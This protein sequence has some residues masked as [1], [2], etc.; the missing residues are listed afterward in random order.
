M[1]SSVQRRIA[2]IGGGITG[3]AAAHRLHELLPTA[4]ISL[5]EGSDR[6]G[7]VLHS[8]ERDGY[9]IERSADMFNTREPWAL[10]LAQR[11]GLTN[12]LINTDPRFRRAF[13][14]HRGK[15]CPVPEGF[16]LMSPAKVWPILKTPLLSP[17]GKLRLASE[18]FI[19]GKRDDQDESLTSFALR[20]FGREAFDR[21][22]QP[23]IGGIYT[24]DPDRLSMQATLK[25]FVEHERKYG[26]LIRAMR[27]MQ[28]TQP[29][30][31]K[32]AAAS[33]A[34]YG[35]FL[36]PRLG[37]SQL[38]DAIANHLPAGSIRLNARIERL[39]RTPHD[40]GVNWCLFVQGS[41]AP[42][43]FDD[44]IVASPA[45][46]CPPLL[47]RI[48]PQL[49]GLVKLIPH[50]G[51]S[52]AVMG[53]KR[54][55]FTHPLDGFGFVAPRVENRRIIAGSLAS[56]KFAGRAPDGRILLR[57]FVGGA[58]QPELNELDDQGIEQLVRKEL[59]EL[60][61]ATG[62]P[63]FCQVNRWHGVMPQ[64]HVGHLDLVAKIDAA[65]NAIPHF[66]LAG[67]AYH[68]VGI[69]FCVRSGEEAAERIASAM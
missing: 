33:G 15:L 5:F 7:G 67:N 27:A 2:V 49:S 23:L 17:L 60:L 16:T 58:L 31:P 57:V 39:E 66:A 44:V 3:L 30:K 34:R 35:Q 40:S 32:E 37:M 50:A 51:C 4:K 43:T 68:G 47:E 26:S 52:V 46:S 22:I 1:S 48:A 13:V 54:E 14:V 19:P 24:A 55:Q 65:A 29:G 9:L 36:A 8:V 42:L 6:L 61:G 12:E 59:G 28:K 18:Y 63:E 41:P 25:Q 56:V 69:P 62:E 11:V 45:H 53:Y 21:L 10:E 64:Y 20:R 38:I